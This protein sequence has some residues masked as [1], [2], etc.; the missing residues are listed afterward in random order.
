MSINYKEK[1]LKYK[2]KYLNLSKSKKQLLGAGYNNNS[3][4]QYRQHRVNENNDATIS[5]EDEL[6]EENDDCVLCLLKL[7]INPDDNDKKLLLPV[8]SKTFP[9]SHIFHDFCLKGSLK[10]TKMCPICRTNITNIYNLNRATMT[11]DIQKHRR[12]PVPVHKPYRL[13]GYDEDNIRLSS[14]MEY[15]EQKYINQLITQEEMQEFQSI[16]DNMFT[17]FNDRRAER[18]LLSADERELM[19]YELNEYIRNLRSGYGGFEEIEEALN[20]KQYDEEVDEQEEWEKYISYVNEI[21]DQERIA[22]TAEIDEIAADQK[23]WRLFKLFAHISGS[24][25]TI[26]TIAEYEIIPH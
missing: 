19:A 21:N 2:K 7:N 14:F 24:A 17:A 9:C 16:Y 20:I 22:E 8:L 25:I 12:L 23:N 15:V 5:R 18:A 3:P 13:L 1:Y 6:N 10:V 11:W 26:S 4:K